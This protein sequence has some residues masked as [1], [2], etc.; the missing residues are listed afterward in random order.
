MNH[1]ARKGHE[2]GADLAV[3]RS[4]VSNPSWPVG[5]PFVFFVVQRS[6]G[7]LTPPANRAW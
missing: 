1:E 7:Q 5:F 2:D 4:A 6:W 3:A